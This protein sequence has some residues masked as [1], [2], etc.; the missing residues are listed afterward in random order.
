ME[1]PLVT[2]TGKHAGRAH[3]IWGASKADRWFPCPGSIRLEQELPDG[4][5]VSSSYATEGKAMH[6]LA[7]HCLRLG[8]NASDGLG[9]EFH[10]VT[11]EDEHCE[12]VQVYLDVIRDDWLNDGGDL[13]IEHTFDLSEIWD[14]LFGTNDAC[15]VAPGL[16]RVY[17]FK[18]GKGVFVPAKDNKQL[19]IYGVGAFRTLQGV[20]AFDRIELVIVQ[21]RCPA[22]ELVRRW[23]I[24]VVDLWEWIEVLRTALNATMAPDAP[25]NPGHH[26]IFCP[27]KPRCPAIADWALAQARMD[28][29]SA[30]PVPNLLSPAE[31]LALL[32]KVELMD[33]FI[34]AV[35]A[36]ALALAEGGVDLPGWKL[37]PKRA[38]RRWKDPEGAKQYL[39]RNGMTPAQVHEDP[40]LRSPAQMEKVA[41][42]HLRHL[43]K[44]QAEGGPVTLVNAI[45]SG[46]NL[47]PM[48]DTR[49]AQ[50]PAI[51]GEFKRLDD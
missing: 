1:D 39:L 24:N 16:L 22:S 36:H 3:S 51:E 25:L 40:E 10:G 8:L 41:P 11:M 32:P 5:S 34:S 19:L 44:A 49:D 26:C 33:V 21:P 45:S 15:L 27:A 28:F 47:V 37:V 38:T 14:G 20:H 35:R 18:G 46:H 43:F 50:R 31:V 13:L 23:E 17:D 42:K 30:P 2:F 7:E 4:E 12:A 29:G 9:A 6:A 48:I